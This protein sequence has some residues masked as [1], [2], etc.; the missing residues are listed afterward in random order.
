M[1]GIHGGTTNKLTRK[2]TFFFIT[3][4]ILFVLMVCINFCLFAAIS[5]LSD[6]HDTVLILKQKNSLLLRIKIL[7]IIFFQSV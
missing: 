5:I 4:E 7:H 3:V 6:Q 1:G 2:K